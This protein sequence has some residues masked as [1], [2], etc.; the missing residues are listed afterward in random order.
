MHVCMQLT[1]AP[2]VLYMGI[3]GLLILESHIITVMANNGTSVGAEKQIHSTDFI[4]LQYKYHR[5]C[6]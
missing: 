4:H 5:T 1:I 6:L 2:E 3:S